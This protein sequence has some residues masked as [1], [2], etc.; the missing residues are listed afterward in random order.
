MV[1]ARQKSKAR[2]EGRECAM[3]MT[4]GR[5][6]LRMRQWV[7]RGLREG[8]SL[9]NCWGRSSTLR[10]NTGHSW[11]TQGAQRVWS[12]ASIGERS[13][14]DLRS[15]RQSGWWSL[16]RVSGHREDSRA[17]L[18]TRKPLSSFWAE[19]IHGQTHSSQS[20]LVKIHYWN[21]EMFPN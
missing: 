8:S 6:R 2:K 16:C 14:A 9:Q 7:S 5:G 13:G 4:A 1:S 21:I 19:E 18:L 12:R 17:C 10:G 3:G 20:N 15:G 11:G